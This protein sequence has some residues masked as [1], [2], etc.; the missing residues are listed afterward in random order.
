MGLVRRPRCS[1][2][3]GVCSW[4]LY[5]A[6]CFSPCSV[7][8]AELHFYGSRCM[9]HL[10]MTEL[11]LDRTSSSSSSMHAM[12]DGPTALATPSVH[13]AGPRR[14]QPP[15]CPHV[16][17]ISCLRSIICHSWPLALSEILGSPDSRT[18]RTDI[19]QLPRAVYAQARAK[20]RLSMSVDRCKRKRADY[21]MDREQR[22]PGTLSF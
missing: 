14:A 21:G 2:F 11:R 22:R 3:L 19:D 1:F 5:C 10:A 6:A 9:R 12:H 13:N 17:V 16:E 4:G 15:T 7:G 18:T 20:D 8:V